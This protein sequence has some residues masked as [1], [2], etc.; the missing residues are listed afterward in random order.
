MQAI[1]EQGG[2]HLPQGGGHLPAE[3]TYRNPTVWG[4][5]LWTVLY[6]LAGVE[7]AAA[8]LRNAVSLLP[9][10]IPCPVCQVNC[11]EFLRDYPADEFIVSRD[12]YLQYLTILRAFIRK[13]LGKPDYALLLSDAETRFAAEYPRRQKA[14]AEMRSVLLDYGKNLEFVPFLHRHPVAARLQRFSSLVA[15]LA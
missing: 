10:I 5:A 13:K 11:R 2:G 6:S 14:V 7:D 9:S 1:P 3:A 12:T 15:K 4:P 8:K